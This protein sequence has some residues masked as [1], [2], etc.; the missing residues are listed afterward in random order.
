MSRQRKATVGSS[1]ESFLAEQ[2]TLTETT[3][4]AVKRVI[5]FQLAKAMEE[6]SISKSA[7]AKRMHTSRSQ[8]DRVLDPDNNGVTL[9]VLMNAAQ[10]VGRKLAI[11]FQK[12]S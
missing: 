1:F 5:A 8:V 7:L 11:E 12:N 9:E 4:R 10:A 6:Q 3:N 2:G